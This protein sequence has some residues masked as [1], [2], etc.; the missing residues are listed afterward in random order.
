MNRKLIRPD[1]T[2]ARDAAAEKRK[3]P[4]ADN[5]AAEAYY[6]VKQMSGR[7]PMVV[8]LLDGEVLNGV[9]EWYDAST[10][11]LHRRG[12]PNLLVFKHAIKHMHKEGDTG[13]L[14]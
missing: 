10:I 6:Y 1:M 4:P 13:S 9:I 8:T 11:K 3:K 5:T 7:T 12:A 14:E 2:A